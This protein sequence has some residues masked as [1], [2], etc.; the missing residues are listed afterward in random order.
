MC[1]KII[2]AESGFR[3]SQDTEVTGLEIITDDTEIGL[4]LL[5]KSEESEVAV[6]RG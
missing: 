6:V 2:I 1:S 5:R 4:L 3:F